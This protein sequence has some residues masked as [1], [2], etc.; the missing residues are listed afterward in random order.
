[1]RGVR[2]AASRGRLWEAALAVDWAPGF[3]SLP[4]SLSFVL[5][6]VNAE[7]ALGC[8]GRQAFD[9]RGAGGAQLQTPAMP[10]LLPDDADLRSLS[11]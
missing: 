1:M 11:K 10:M 3:P 7:A 5:H 9:A 8:A 2:T 6:G 4:L